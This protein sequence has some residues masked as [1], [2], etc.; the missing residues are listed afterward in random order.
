MEPFYIVLSIFLA[1]ML[2][3]DIA[4]FVRGDRPDWKEG[5]VTFL[6]FVGFLAAMQMAFQIV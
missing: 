3:Y 2:S 5:L 1:A 6:V 4:K